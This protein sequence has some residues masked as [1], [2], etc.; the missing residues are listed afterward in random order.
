MPPYRELTSHWSDFIVAPILGVAASGYLPA[1]WFFPSISTLPPLVAKHGTL[2]IEIVSHCWNYSHL[3][4]YQLSSL[5]NFPPQD[6]RVK[7]TVF[8]AEEDKHTQAVLEFFAGIEVQNVEWHWQPFE[9]QRL[10]RRSIG[11]NIAAKQTQADWLWFTD[12]DLV[13]HESCLDSL[14]QA[15]QGRTDPLVF[16]SQEYVTKLLS[17]DNPLFDFS[18]ENIAIQDIPMDDFDVVERDRAIGPLQITHGDVARALGYCNDIAYYQRPAD[19]W[20]KCREDRAFR[21]LL[22]SEGVKVAIPGVCRILHIEKG[23]D[24]DQQADL[25]WRRHLRRLRNGERGV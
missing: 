2:K 24:S 21:W 1:R 4:V 7:M 22:G 19:S 3:L 13:F 17:A 25:S 9:K 20:R 11:R 15:L 16:P 18:S 6:V 10:F 5:V 23:R 8:Y 12:C 14:A